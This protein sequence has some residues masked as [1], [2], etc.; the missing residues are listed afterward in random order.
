MELIIKNFGSFE[1]FKNSFKLLAKENFGSGWTWAAIKDNNLVLINS[2]NANTLV[3]EI[4]VTVL[5]TLD[6]WEHSYY[7]D[8]QSNRDKYIEIFWK[9]INWDFVE[10]RI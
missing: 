7:L 4:G 3:N 5:F 9:L 1:K 8:S 10:S 2:S 6:V